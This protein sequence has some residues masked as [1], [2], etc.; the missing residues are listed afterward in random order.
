MQYNTVYAH[1]RNAVHHVHATVSFAY[2]G[3][4]QQFSDD[5]VVYES[6]VHRVLVRPNRVYIEC[7]GDLSELAS[8][9]SSEQ[10][11]AVFQPILAPLSLRCELRDCNVYGTNEGG[12]FVVL[13]R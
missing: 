13:H 11:L 5:P 10:L 9:C 2:E 1:K 6:D 3:Y 8:V 12:T 7:C 4:A